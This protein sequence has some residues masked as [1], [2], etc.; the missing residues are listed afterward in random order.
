MRRQAKTKR[1]CTVALRSFLELAGPAGSAGKTL[2][3]WQGEGHLEASVDLETGYKWKMPHG[4]LRLY[5]QASVRED[6]FR[7]LPEHFVDS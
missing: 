2:S 6:M 3:P 4:S 1:S 5:S 7:A